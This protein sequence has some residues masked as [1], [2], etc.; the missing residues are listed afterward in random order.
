MTTTTRL[1]TPRARWLDLPVPAAITIC[2]FCL[3]G[4]AALVGKIQSEHSAVVSPT[5][6]LPI[7]IIATAP[8]VMPPTAVPIQVAAV[9][10]NA[11]RRAVVAYD[12][13]AG[14]VLGAIEQGRSY[15]VLA[16]FGSDWLQADVMG[17]G[18]VWL[19][20]DQVLDLPP[21][22]VDMQPA[23]QPQVIYQVVNQ[24]PDQAAPLQQ[25]QQTV[26]DVQAAITPPA[27]AAPIVVDDP[28]KVRTESDCNAEHGRC[29][30]PCTA[31]HGRCTPEAAPA[32]YTVDNAPAPAPAADH[33]LPP[34]PPDDTTRALMQAA[35]RQEHCV[36]GVCR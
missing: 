33:A 12:A 4:I 21:G 9:L 17:S 20:A 27:P 24:P 28:L 18:V 1:N 13:P 25:F 32:P 14:N 30:P 34:S 23:P 16:R 6:P 31:E 35:W 11:L 5:A 26:E 8:A 22:L 36:A 7:I 3:L 29:E 15:A 2:I 19:K 10:P